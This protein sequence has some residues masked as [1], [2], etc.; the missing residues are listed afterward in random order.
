MTLPSFA[1]HWVKIKRAA[2]V[3]DHGSWYDDWDNPEPVRTIEG[4]LVSPGVSIEDNDRQ[5]AQQV[6]YTVLAPA[7]TDIL[8]T[9]KVEVELEPGLDLAVYGRPKRIPSPT[10]RLDH[11]QIELQEWKES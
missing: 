4:C 2:Q 7:G 8:T 3:K 5:D 9:D 6:A 1:R 11:L 10:G